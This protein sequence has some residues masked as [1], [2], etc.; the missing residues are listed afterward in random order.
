MHPE[1]RAQYKY[2]EVDGIPTDGLGAIQT[3]MSMQSRRS[4]ELDHNLNHSRSNSWSLRS[5]ITGKFEGGGAGRFRAGSTGDLQQQQQQHLMR[6]YDVE[7]HG[8]GELAEDSDEDSGSGRK[9]TSFE[10]PRRA[11]TNAGESAYA[12]AAPPRRSRTVESERVSAA[13][14]K[15]FQ[16]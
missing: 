10:D 13:A 1:G 12:A 14:Q 16:R 8:L 7:A 15:G 4:A 6:S 9:R 11:E 5:P 2:V 3:R